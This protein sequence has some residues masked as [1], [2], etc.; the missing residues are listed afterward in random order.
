[1][2]RFG[3]GN[4]TLQDTGPATDRQPWEIS[5]RTQQRFGQDTFG[6]TTTEIL[7]VGIR[8]S[9]HTIWMFRTRTRRNCLEKLSLWKSKRCGH[10]IRIHCTA[11]R[12]PCGTSAPVIASVF[13]R[14]VLIP[15][16]T[17]IITTR[18]ADIG[19]LTP[20][21]PCGHKLNTTRP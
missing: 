16:A 19:K 9:G 8:Q 17:A 5:R 7:V 6:I 11:N 18:F 12:E 4:I 21:I 14:S 10:D 20:G 15:Q 13:S 2:Q 3:S 1:M